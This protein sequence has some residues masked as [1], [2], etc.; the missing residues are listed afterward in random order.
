MSATA[1]GGSE[2]YEEYTIQVYEGDTLVLEEASAKA[3]VTPAISGS[4]Y[5]AIVTVKDSH[6]AEATAEKNIFGRVFPKSGTDALQS[7]FP[8]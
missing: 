1:I 2:V 3:I 7:F 5:K 4:T 8:S 6:G